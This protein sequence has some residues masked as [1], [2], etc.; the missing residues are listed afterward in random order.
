M[1]YNKSLF[2]WAGGKGKALKHVLPILEQHKRKVFV[3]P[4]VGAANVSLNFDCDEYIWNDINKELMN[5]YK[6]LLSAD[7]NKQDYINKCNK[8][9]SSGYESYYE[10]R[11]RF[12]NT[13]DKIEK[14]TILQFLNKHAFNGLYRTNKS[15]KFNVPIGTVKKNPPNVPVESID[16][17]VNRH[18]NNTK[19]LCQSYNS[20]FA[21][22]EEMEDCLIYCDSPYAPLTTEFKYS[23][24]GFNKD[25]HIK[26]K[27][28][29]KNS[30]HTTILSNHWT[31][32]T[33]ELYKDADE[34][35]TFPVQRTISC[36]G[37]DRK[38]VEEVVAVYLG[39]DNEL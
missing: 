30:K 22:A 37:G 20:V 26:L 24:G 9:F 25:D 36:K 39:E 11:D 8:I 12:N 29:A 13:E 7:K 33:K 5:T 34:L 18:K 28:L 6:Y 15:G 23:A 21:V 16:I 17:L 38:K 2:K 14:L 10:L 3:E 1:R 35:Y 19:L 27:E 4:F 31:D 32:F